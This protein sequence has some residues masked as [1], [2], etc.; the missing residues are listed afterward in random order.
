MTDALAAAVREIERHVASLGWDA[1]TKLFA[2]V[3]TS[4][5]LAGQPGLADAL[6][7]GGVSGLPDDH[8]TSVEQDDL[9]PHDSV[10][11][12]LRQIAWP[13]EVVGA[14]LVVERLTLPPEVEPELPA[15]AEEAQQFAAT[16]PL[17]HEVRLAV[18]VLRDGRRACALRSRA[19][20]ADDAVLTGPDLAPDLADALAVTL[21]G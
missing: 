20:D 10:L 13:P 11:T 21:D 16:H 6:A 18:G 5:L 8:L 14:A 4:A 3:P 7:P 9:P 15:D 12:L 1:P 2:L 17:R 19:H